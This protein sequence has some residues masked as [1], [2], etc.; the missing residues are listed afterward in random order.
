[1][2][3]IEICHNQRNDVQGYRF[4]SQ[5]VYQ[6]LSYCIFISYCEQESMNNYAE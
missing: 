1:M 5:S 3:N 2:E 4:L 6:R